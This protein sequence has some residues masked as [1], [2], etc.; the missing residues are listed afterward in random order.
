MSLPRL[1]AQVSYRNPES[2]YRCSNRCLIAVSCPDCL[3]QCVKKC[4]CLRA[5]SSRVFDVLLLLLSGDVELN[6]GPGSATRSKSESAS[7]EGIYE[8]VRRLEQGQILD[9]K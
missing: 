2:C 8:I 7:L 1:F 9:F 4:M 3:F 6:P 5:F